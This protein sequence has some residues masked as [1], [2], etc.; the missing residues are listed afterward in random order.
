MMYYNKNVMKAAGLDP[1][2]PPRDW[3]SLRDAAMKITKRDASG[4]LLVAG[5]VQDDWTIL[6][7]FQAALYGFGGKLLS[8]DGTKSAF[9]SQEGKDALQTL[10]DMIV[11]DKVGDVAWGGELQGTPTEPFVVDKQGFMFDVAAAAKRFAANAPNFVNWGVV[12]M[13]AGPKGFK[14]VSRPP[15]LMIP[16]AAKNPDQAWRVIEYWLATKVE[17]RWALDILRAPTTLSAEA[18]PALKKNMVISVLAE[19]LKNTTDTPKTKHW[20][21]MI[22]TIGAETLN[23]L[24]GK[25]TAAQA[26]DDAAATVDKALNT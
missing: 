1:E 15:A 19:T 26:L 20:A 14:E 3:A 22:N 8:D 18:D 23:A 6:R 21:E 2:N 17:L 5:L 9:N 10:V 16:K 4:K 7:T 13:P 11:K 25:K 24:T 12:S